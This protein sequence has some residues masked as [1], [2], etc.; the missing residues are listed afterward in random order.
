M[1]SACASIAATGRSPR[2][3]EIGWFS[4]AYRRPI[5]GRAPAAA[6]IA[7]DCRR[8]RP[9]QM[10]ETLVKAARRRV[11]SKAEHCRAGEFVVKDRQ[12]GLRM[13]LIEEIERKVADHPFRL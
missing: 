3:N 7:E 5:G 13:V 1:I 10:Q 9:N 11:R 2:L 6:T 12:D 4:R 8:L